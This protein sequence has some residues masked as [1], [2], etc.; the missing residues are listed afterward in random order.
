MAI[1]CTNF[2]IPWPSKICPILDFWFESKPSGNPAEIPKNHPFLVFP[3]FSSQE[4]KFD[5]FDASAIKKCSNACL[6]QFVGQ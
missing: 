1:A 3:P 5:K 2:F 6:H 4:M